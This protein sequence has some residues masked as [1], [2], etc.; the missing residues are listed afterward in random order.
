[1]DLINVNYDG[2][3]EVKA[4]NM[5]SLGFDGLLCKEVNT[6]RK[7]GGFGVKNIYVKK[8]YEIMKE[9][10]YEPIQ[11]G[12]SLNNETSET[13]ASD[14]LMFTII[15][16]RYAGGGMNYNPY[17]SINDG[18]LEGFL[19]KNIGKKE[20]GK[21]IWHV[22]A[23]KDEE[24]ITSKKDKN[25]FNRFN[26]NYMQGIELARINLRHVNDGCEYYFNVDGEHHII[27]NPRLPL[28]VKVLPK[29]TNVLYLPD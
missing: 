12:F 1:M 29:A 8:M 9:K 2:G 11:I 13:L 14:I 15:N 20:I 16:G 25:G 7:K 19:V 26:I 23:K 3:K 22:L 17:F 5:F 21:L 4:M 6:S 27:E 18:A 28:E 24:H 10:R